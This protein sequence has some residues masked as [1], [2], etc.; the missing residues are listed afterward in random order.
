L[1]PFN[2]AEE[3]LDAAAWDDDG[4]ERIDVLFKAL[5]EAGVDAKLMMQYISDATLDDDDDQKEGKDTT[6]YLGLAVEA[7]RELYEELGL[8]TK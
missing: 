1:P 8:P 2:E 3:I 7:L 4:A 5:T 6:Y